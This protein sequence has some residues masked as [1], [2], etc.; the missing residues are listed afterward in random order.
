MSNLKKNQPFGDLG[1]AT[2]RGIRRCPQCGTV[3]GTRGLSC[4]NSLC[5]MVFKEIIE[6]PKKVNLDPCKIICDQ[7][8][9]WTTFYSVRVKEKC[10][11]YYRGFVEIV[12]EESHTDS[13]E[14]PDDISGSNPMLMPSLENLEISPL[15]AKCY[16]LGCVKRGEI[17]YLTKSGDEVCY[18]ILACASD[19]SNITDAQPFLLKHSVLNSMSIPPD[20]K[21]KIFMK[22]REGPLV[23]RVSP[24]SMVVKCEKDEVN[25]IGFQ[26]TSFIKSNGTNTDQ[27]SRFCC[28]CSLS[29]PSKRKNTSIVSVNVPEV[30]SSNTPLLKARC[31]HFYSCI[32]AFSGETSL[33]REFSKF[34]CDEQVVTSMQQVIAILGDEDNGSIKVEV[35][36]EENLDLFPANDVVLTGKTVD[37]LGDQAIRIEK[38]EFDTEDS[39]TAITLPGLTAEDILESP[40]E[41]LKRDDGSDLLFNSQLSPTLTY[42]PN[43]ISPA[44]NPQEWLASVTERINMT[45]HYG[46]PQQP[47]PLIF[48]IPQTYFNFLLDRISAGTQKKRLPNSTESI[49]RTR[50]PPFGQFT[51]YTWLLTNI[52]HLKRVFDTAIMPLDISRKFSRNSDSSFS[53]INKNPLNEIEVVDGGFSVKKVKLSSTKTMEFK[54]FLKVGQMSSNPRD[55]TP[56]AIHWIPDL[57]P[58]TKVGEL[59][60]KFEFGIDTS[61]K[62]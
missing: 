24:I 30:Y 57:Y 62:S 12:Y 15:R 1:K 42:V 13:S 5:D 23:Q 41:S 7:G 31:L 16:V 38:F 22:A 53:L 61:P 27:G 20:N 54:T 25:V 3:N 6:K 4:K 36:G 34:I 2:K 33:A 29:M 48:H 47:E 26:H 17:V 32:A 58:K 49:R 46:Q 19:R 44:W 8:S 10:P 51:K 21:Q 35:M 11:D 37:D 14:A 50:N 55:V 43:V 28:S 18:H 9:P 60:V 40:T 59:S 45:M 56:F 39:S 52:F